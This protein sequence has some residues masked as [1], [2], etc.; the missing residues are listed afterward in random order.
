MIQF[1][2]PSVHSY[3]TLSYLILWHYN[4]CTWL[5]DIYKRIQK[6]WKIAHNGGFDWLFE[7]KTWKKK[8]QKYPNA[9]HHFRTQ[10]I[11]VSRILSL[12]SQ[13][14]DVENTRAMIL[15]YIN[16]NTRIIQLLFTWQVN[17]EEIQSHHH[18]T[19]PIYS[20]FAYNRSSDILTKYRGR[21]NETRSEKKKRKESIVDQVSRMNERKTRISR[22]FSLSSFTLDTRIS[23]GAKWR[24]A[25]SQ[26]HWETAVF[27]REIADHFPRRRPP[28]NKNGAASKISL[29]FHRTCLSDTLPSPRRGGER[30][31]RNPIFIIYIYYLFF[32]ITY[33]YIILTPSSKEC[34]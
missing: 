32:I 20:Q 5:Y 24:F 13:K 17:W 6:L 1:L 9:F 15:E 18:Q 25:W 23:G 21:R 4:F 14:C 10:Q 19:Y 3:L 31:P 12:S 27:G 7:R 29:F 22:I 30:V 11:S 33:F 16:T 34:N 2:N 8:I 26:K 28:A